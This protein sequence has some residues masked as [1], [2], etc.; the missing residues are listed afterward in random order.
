MIIFFFVHS[1][2]VYLQHDGRFQ[3]ARGV[4]ENYVFG[5]FLAECIGLGIASFTVLLL[6]IGLSRHQSLLLIPHLIIQAIS[7]VLFALLVIAGIIAVTTD[8][9]VFYRLINAAPFVEHPSYSTVGLDGGTM[10]RIYFLL[11]LYGI[12]FFLEIWFITIIYSCVRYLDE[13]ST[14]MKYCLAFSTPM[15]RLSE[16]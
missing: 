15:K 6:L 12:S 7:V 11:T 2:L 4:K 1:L 3:E 9:A 10:L 5:S 16:R 14:Y 13:R 8:L